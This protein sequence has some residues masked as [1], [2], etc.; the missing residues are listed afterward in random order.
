MS[1]LISFN[2]RE[3]TLRTLNNMNFRMS[4]QI[5]LLTSSQRKTRM[6]R[7]ETNNCWNVKRWSRK[8]RIA[9]TKRILSLFFRKF[10]SFEILK[11]KS[12]SRIWRWEYSQTVHVLIFITLVAWHWTT[13]CEI[14]FNIWSNFLIFRKLLLTSFWRSTSFSFCER[15]I[16][17]TKTTRLRKAKCA[18]RDDEREKMIKNMTSTMTKISMTSK[19]RTTNRLIWNDE[20]LWNENALSEWFLT[21]RKRLKLFVFWSRNKF[22]RSRLLYDCCWARRLWS[23][24]FSIFTI[25]CAFSEMKSWRRWKKM[26]RKSK[27]TTKS[28]RFWSIIIWR[29][30]WSENI[31]EFWTHTFSK[32]LSSHSQKMFQ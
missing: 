8:F 12:F 16:R 1:I 18:K 5:Q 27:I 19:I 29:R 14:C 6:K 32:N 3:R 20:F 11:L 15:N 7:N 21:K 22:C 30:T 31:D 26:C 23:T 17:A 25:Y 10:F 2:R 28:K 4:T 13:T 9:N 24:K